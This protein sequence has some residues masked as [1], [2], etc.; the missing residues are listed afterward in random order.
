[1]VGTWYLWVSLKGRPQLSSS[2]ILQRRNA[3]PLLADLSNFQ[4]LEV[5]VKSSGL[6]MLSMMPRVKQNISCEIA[7]RQIQ[8]NR[9]YSGGH[10][11]V[12][13]WGETGRQLLKGCKLEVRRLTSLG[14]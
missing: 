10:Q 12:R 3:G 1:M 14:I 11:E 13:R 6:G 9:E 5:Y 2:Q 8:R 4:N 7:K